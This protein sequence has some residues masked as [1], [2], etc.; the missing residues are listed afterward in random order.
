MVFIHV[1][2]GK[3]GSTFL[4]DKV[5]PYLSN[6]NYIGITSEKREQ[7]LLQLHYYDD[8][9]F[10]KEKQTIKD[11]FQKKIISNQ[12]NLLSSEVFT[13]QGSNVVTQ[14]HRLK[15]IFNQAKIILVLREPIDAMLSFYKYNVSEGNILSDFQSSI[16]YKRTPMVFFKRKPIYLADFY[17]NE[18]INFY[19]NLFGNENVCV[20][21]YED[22]KDSPDYFFQTLSTFMET[23]FDI[24]K[25]KQS[26]NE[27]INS[28]PK[29]NSIDTLRALTLYKKLKS[30]FPK[31]NINLNDIVIENKPIISD[32][33]KDK[34]INALKGKCY[35]YY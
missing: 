6:L 18:I 22:M 20:L 19:H 15:F 11:Y 8:I 17:Y 24:P 16:E 29:D 25:I 12:P 28:S 3:T 9:K 5:F 13:L 21:K 33:L 32:N 7:E 35:D 26:L 27:K 2:F 14:A 23:P 34:I 30:E 1:G 31:S 4:Q 10:Q